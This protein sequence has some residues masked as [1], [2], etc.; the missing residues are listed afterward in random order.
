M[1]FKTLNILIIA[2]IVIV[3]SANLYLL[4]RY[5]QAKINQV[6]LSSLR[7]S[8]FD[9]SLH[10]NSHFKG[11][12]TESLHI[13]LDRTNANNNIIQALFIYDANDTLYLTTDYSHNQH[14]FYH[15]KALCLNLLTA[16]TLQHTKT[17]SL[18]IYKLEGMQKIPYTLYAQLDADYMHSTL[19]HSRMTE[20]LFSIISLTLFILLYF[21]LHHFF[22]KPIL[23]IDAF[24]KGNLS[25][26]PHSFIQEIEDLSQSIHKHVDKLTN[27]AYIDPLTKV[28]N[29]RSIEDALDLAI[30]SAKRDESSFGVA[31]LDLDAFKQINDTLG[32]AVGDQVLM[33][34]SQKIKSDLRAV[35]QLGRLGGDE[36]LIIF[37][38]DKQ[39][40]RILQALERVRKLFINPFIIAG[41]EIKITIS[42]GV[43]YYPKDALTKE[44]LLLQA[45]KAMYHAKE[46]GGNKV[47]RS[48]RIS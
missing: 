12:D 17:V 41:H 36:F 40:E 20:L 35:D 15:Q 25:T 11:P 4:D 19:F 46:S 43:T 47:V 22:I 23:Q 48:D 13:L 16:D 9:L 27:M 33:V 24:F 2:F 44:E 6:L 39:Q 8:L 5:S 3:A 37:H 18:P 34:L 42:I 31:M 29:R 38:H 1:R 21:V 28:Q 26:L 32:H 7:Q 30:A 14:L 45:D 10:L